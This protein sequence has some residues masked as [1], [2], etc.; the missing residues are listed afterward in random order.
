M[1]MSDLVKV[2]FVTGGFM[3][4]AI[5][6]QSLIAKHVA[7]TLATAAEALAENARANHAAV[8]ATTEIARLNVELLKAT[9]L[10]TGPK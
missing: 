1:S 3:L 4:A 9:V 6:I 7:Q 8:T 10:N 2:A 5:W